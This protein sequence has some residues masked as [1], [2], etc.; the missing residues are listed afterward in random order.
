MIRIGKYSFGAHSNN[1]TTKGPKKRW[2]C[3]ADTPVF[4]TNSRGYPM[5]RIGK[6]NFGEHSK[7]KITKGPKKRWQCGMVRKG[8]RAFLVTF[9]DEIISCRNEHNH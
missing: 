9:E 4:T 7:N 3:T 2:Q 6:Y 5:I 8:C 1:K